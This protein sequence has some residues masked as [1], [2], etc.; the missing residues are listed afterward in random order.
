MKKPNPERERLRA[1]AARRAQ[2]AGPP[3]LPA[4]PKDMPRPRFASEAEE[5]RFLKAYDFA[6]YWEARSESSAEKAQLNAL[7]KQ[8]RESVYRLRLADSEIA[9]LQSRAKE[10]GVPVSVVLRGLIKEFSTAPTG[11]AIAIEPHPSPALVAAPRK[12][13][14]PLAAFA[15]LRVVNGGRFVPRVR[16]WIQ[17]LRMNGAELFTREMPGRWSCAPEPFSPAADGSF[18]F[19]VSKVALGYIADFATMEDHAVALAIKYSDGSCWGWPPDSYQHGGRHPDWS[20]PAEPLR[21]RARI[22]ADGR[23]YQEEFLLDGS[24]PPEAFSVRSFNNVV[25]MPKTSAAATE[26]DN[27]QRSQSLRSV[28]QTRRPAR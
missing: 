25:P 22:L 6:A 21:V 11:G 24:A 1:A 27:F 23:D 26:V 5:A 28:V 17:F 10:L 7:G 19:D 4:W 16:C 15:H 14:K 13:D 20:L 8:A 12:G 3:K 9:F 2:Q 18:V